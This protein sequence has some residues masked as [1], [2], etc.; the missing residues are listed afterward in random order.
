MD[1]D[2]LGRLKD[3]TLSAGVGSLMVSAGPNLK[4]MAGCSLNPHERAF[5]LFIGPAGLSAVLPKMEEENV[6]SFL[7]GGASL[8]PYLDEEGPFRATACAARHAGVEAKGELAIGAEFLHMRV[9]ELELVKSV[10]SD[11]R[12]YD[13]DGIF[14][15]LRR[16]KDAAE[17]DLIRKA[18]AIVDI[19]IE[20]ARRQ[21]K[22]GVTEKRVAERIEAAMITAGA[23]AVPFNIVLSGPKSALPHGEPDG[24]PI[25]EGELVVCDIG[26]VYKGYFADITRTLPAGKTPAGLARIHAVVCAA[27]EAGR[28][29]ARPGLACQD[30]DA[31]CREVIEAAGL[32]DRFTHRTGHGLG[33]EVHEEPYIVKGNVMKLAPGMVFTIEPGVYVPGLGGVRIEDDVAITDDGVEVLTKSPR[34]LDF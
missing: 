29:A 2:R 1:L 9:K 22:P 5:I 4:Y 15:S 7:G 27:N 6:A 28:K 19:G 23:D 25:E 14:T 26:A 34:E 10:L 16:R 13:V 20:E 21:I 18:A 11:F 33:L 24:K 30:L 31:V 17:L 12:P 8:F 3:A 32:G